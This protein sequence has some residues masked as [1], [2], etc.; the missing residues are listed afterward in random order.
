MNQRYQTHPRRK[1]TTVVVCPHGC[2]RA[3]RKNGTWTAVTATAIENLRRSARRGLICTSDCPCPD[4]VR[5]LY[6][7]AA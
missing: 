5:H 7:T 4:C 3:R 1:E 6:R 2:G